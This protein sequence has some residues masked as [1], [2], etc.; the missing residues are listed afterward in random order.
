VTGL[1][2]GGH[3]LSAGGDVMD[4]VAACAR[5][6]LRLHG[7]HPGASVELL[8]VS[9]NAT[10]LVSDPDAEPSVLRVHR[11]GYHNRDE[12]LSELAWMAALRSSAGISTPQAV[13]TT[14]G[15]L[16]VTVADPAG[17]ESRHVVMFELLPGSE[18]SAPDA[19]TFAVLGELTARMHSHSR[20]W[21]RPAA[22]TRFHWDF[23][24]A[25]GRLARWGRW[26]SAPGIGPSE[27]EVLGKLE[28]TLSR[29]LAAYGSG[30]E[31]YGLVHADLRLANLLVDPQT[32]SV[33]DFDDC[34]FS[35]YLYD[36]A[37]AVSFFEHDDAVPALIDS[38]LGGY[39]RHVALSDEEETEIWSFVL[40][41]RLLL[42]AWIGS[43][44]EVDIARQLGAGYTADS[45]ELADRYLE[46]YG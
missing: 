11:L 43:H 20:S 15:E 42:L 12:I 14:S 6:A 25:F 27:Q 45:C 8:S 46:R 17:G 33:I 5:A 18:P 38:W 16:V 44:G 26:Q 30:P 21:K 7:C 41:R 19:E 10:F 22:F 24:A 32:L 2:P 13:P 9:E 36:L 29:R 3:D 34:G 23:D 4:H 37:T 28:L 1:H 35:W 40:F 31:R 39:R